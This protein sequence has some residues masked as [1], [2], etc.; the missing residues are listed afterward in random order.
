M[1]RAHQRRSGEDQ[2]DQQAI[3]QR[4]Q[5]SAGIDHQAAVDREQALEREC[6]CRSNRDPDEDSRKAADHRRCEYL[7]RIDARDIAA[8]RTKD[9]ERS[10]ALPAGVEI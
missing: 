8:A 10:D 1:A 3:G 9:L 7:Q 4:Q 6:Q 5:D 2:G